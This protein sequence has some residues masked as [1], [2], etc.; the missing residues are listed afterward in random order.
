M[1]AVESLHREVRGKGGVASIFTNPASWLRMVTALLK[2]ISNERL[3][4]RII[5]IFQGRI[6]SSRRVQR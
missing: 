1:N 5:L 2:E 6:L 4:G 3:T